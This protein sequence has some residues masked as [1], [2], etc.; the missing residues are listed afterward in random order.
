MSN[1]SN[2]LFVPLVFHRNR[3]PSP[4]GGEEEGLPIRF[5]FMDQG[6]QSDQQRQPLSL[7]A[8][9]QA[10]GLRLDQSLQPPPAAN[11]SHPPPPPQPTMPT[12]EE[13]LA[14]FRRIAEQ[15]QSQLQRYE[16]QQQAQMQAFQQSQDTVAQLSQALATLTANAAAPTPA[17]PQKKKPDLPPWEPKK[18]NIWIRRV[19]AA[20]Q[21]AGIVNPKDK[22]AFLESMFEVNGNPK[23]N[24]FLYGANTE[25]DWDNFLAYLREEYGKTIRQKAEIL[26]KECPRQGLKP[27]QF[28]SQ[29]NEDTQGVEIDHIKR[30]HLL[31]SLPSRVRELLGKSVE[32][33]TAAQVAAKAD[34]YFD[35]QGNLLERS[36]HG[37]SSINP[38]PSNSS[39]TPAFSDEEDADDINHIRRGGATAR[40]RPN[41]SRSRTRFNNGNKNASASNSNRSPSVPARLID[42]LCRFHHKFG[43]EA[44]KCA[45]GCKKAHLVKKPPGNG[46]GV[47]R[48]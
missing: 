45:D 33:M 48:Q 12:V 11:L 27:S 47:R 7:L 37:I 23:I 13:Q 9:D 3:P 16:Q 19:T 30:E 25:A 15:Q 24:E 18:I 26:I 20:Y 1:N 43:D 21:R 41:R 10:N 22:F 17:P 5:N 44:W 36:S 4:G 28:L 38:L 29:L 42:G 32:T 8:I 46:K 34:D 31:K 40:G 6:D 2:N 14:E 39:F 35:R